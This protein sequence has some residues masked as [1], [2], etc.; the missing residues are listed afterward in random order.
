M[1]SMRSKELGV[2]AIRA[3]VTQ[4]AVGIGEAILN[5]P[6]TTAPMKSRFTTWADAV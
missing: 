5:G 3:E 1:S 2:I 6:T 4:G